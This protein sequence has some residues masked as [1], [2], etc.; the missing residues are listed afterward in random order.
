MTGKI[1]P[2]AYYQVKKAK[3]EPTKDTFGWDFG[4]NL[5]VTQNPN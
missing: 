3:L 1:W 2:H 4:T 5:I